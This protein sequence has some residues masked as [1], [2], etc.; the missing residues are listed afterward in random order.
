MKFSILMPV[1]NVEL[2]WLK[3]AIRSVKKQTYRNWELCLVDDC[4]TDKK[5]PTFLENISE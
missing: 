4:S 2:H 3:E 5:I 1:Y